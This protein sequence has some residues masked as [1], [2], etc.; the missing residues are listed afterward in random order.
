MK[1]FQTLLVGLV[2]ATSVSATCFGSGV[3][4]D[5]RNNAAYH[6]GRA[7]RGYD[8]NAGAFQGW[9]APGETKYACVDG[10]QGIRY[11]FRVGNRNFDTGFDLGDD[12]CAARLGNEI[13]GCD[14][15][16]SST[17]A[18]WEFV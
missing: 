6:A 18:G 1:S 7:C 9:F 2:S 8:G 14:L 4:W 15:G 12:D 11:D 13:W 5:N 16:G 10:G 17:V 3:G